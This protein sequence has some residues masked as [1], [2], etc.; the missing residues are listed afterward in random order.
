MAR[1]DRWA[2]YATITALTLIYLLLPTHNSSLDAWYYAACVRHGHELLL[3]HHLLYNPAGWLWVK[4]LHSVGL[5]PDT[6]AA[7]KALNALAAG[8]CLLV[9]HRLLASRVPKLGGIT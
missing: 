2:A 8:A 3:A 7:L 6:L 1:N 9:L 5:T 4:A